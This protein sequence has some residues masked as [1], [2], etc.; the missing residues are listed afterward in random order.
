MGKT[1]VAGILDQPSDTLVAQPV[2]ETTRAVLEQ[3]IADHVAPGA[4]IY[5][6]DHPSY[7]ELPNHEAVAH[8]QGEYVRGDVHT[9]GIESVWA[10]V[11]R[12]HMGTYHWMS[13]KHLHRYV[14]ELAGRHNLCV[15]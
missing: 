12:M 3:F 10:I 9:N 14:R 13:V 2:T 15:R 8:G 1:P 4:M 5:T 7:R 6:D 11:K